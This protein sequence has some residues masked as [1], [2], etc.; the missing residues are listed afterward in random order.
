MHEYRDA[1]ANL[2]TVIVVDGDVLIRLAISEYLRHCG[3][4]VLEAVSA[5]EAITILRKDNI[6]VDV[7]L[8]DVQ[9]TGSM[10]GFGLSQWVRKNRPGVDVLLAG[11]P[12]RAVDAASGLCESG[13]MLGKPYDPQIVHDGIKKLLAARARQER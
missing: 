3:Y 10:D 5:D 8:T 12:K 4:R 6:R 13:P 2:E 1:A 7:V 11:T 9:T